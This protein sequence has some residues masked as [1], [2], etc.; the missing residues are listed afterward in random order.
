MGDPRHKKSPLPSEEEVDVTPEFIKEA[1]DRMKANEE[2]NEISG[3]QEKDPNYL[4]DSQAA[5]ARWLTKRLGRKVSEKHVSNVLGPVREG[6]KWDRVGRS[7]YV[8][9]IREALRLE[10]TMTITIRA[11]RAEIATIAAWLD[12]LPDDKFEEYRSALERAR[13]PNNKR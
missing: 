2:L 5:L 4:I 8:H 10:R 11:S 6:S 7:T 1:R 9:P 13:T 12:Q 3:A